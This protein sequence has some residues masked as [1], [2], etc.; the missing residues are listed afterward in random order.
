M[1]NHAGLVELAGGDERVRPAYGG[2]HEVEHSER[3]RRQGDHQHQRAY[4]LKIHS[5]TV[6]GQRRG[7]VRG[8]LQQRRTTAAETA[9][10][11]RRTGGGGSCGESL[12]RSDPVEVGAGLWSGVRVGRLGRVGRSWSCWSRERLG[13]RLLGR[14]LRGWRLCHRSIVGRRQPTRLR[15]PCLITDSPR[16]TSCS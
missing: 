12:Q 4:A 11:T 14:W 5:S 13:R 8:R 15:G 6:R 3:K 1:A 9:K 7:T 10:G 2:V 16:A